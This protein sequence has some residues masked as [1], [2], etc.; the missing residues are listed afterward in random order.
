MHETMAANGYWPAAVAATFAGRL[1]GVDFPSANRTFPSF[2]R[3]SADF[4]VIEAWDSFV[5]TV[6]LFAHSAVAD[7]AANRNAA[8]AAANGARI[9]RFMAPPW[10]HPTGRA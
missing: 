10:A 5:C 3:S 2:R 9:F 6:A 1:R 7:G 8:A 4:G